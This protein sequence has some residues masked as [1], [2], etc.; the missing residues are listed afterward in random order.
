M[1]KFDMSLFVKHG[2]EEKFFD[3]Y[4]YVQNN[5]WKFFFLLF[6][7]DFIST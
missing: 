1:H 2:K 5:V 7:Y 3:Y 4:K 6:F